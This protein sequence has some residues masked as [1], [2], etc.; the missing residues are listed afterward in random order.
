MEINF[1][2]NIK[3]NSRTGTIT[4]LT[5]WLVLLFI[6][7]LKN[8]ITK[9]TDYLF[10][11]VSLYILL[12]LFWLFWGSIKIILSSD[13]LI[14]E[15]RLMNIKYWQTSY[16]LNKIEN[17]QKRTNDKADTYS[18]YGKIGS[19]VFSYRPEFLKIYDT[20]PSVI[21]F[22]Y[23]KKKLKIGEGLEE[24]NADLIVQKIKAEKQRLH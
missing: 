7:F 15:K 24:F 5:F 1:E 14:L 20:N 19:G 9:W 4:F 12:Y 3:S 18:S 11:F 8:G 22:T 13:K 2:I 6:I 23:D 21:Y 10:I 17:I 16:D